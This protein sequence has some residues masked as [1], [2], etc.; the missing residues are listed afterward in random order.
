MAKVL[1][2]QAPASGDAKPTVL[3]PFTKASREHSEGAFLDTTVLE[4]TFDAGPTQLAP[5]D[6]PAFGYMRDILLLVEASGGDDGLT[7]AVAQ[8]DAPWSVIRSL[9]LKDVN[10]Q[11]IVGPISGYDLMLL[12]KW[13]GYSFDGDPRR[14]PAFVDVDTNGDFSF[15]LRIPVE[16]VSRNA[17]GALANMNASSTYKLE[18]TVADDADVYSTPPGTTTPDVRIRAWLE[19]WAPPGAQDGRGNAQE[20]EPRGLG[21]TQYSSKATYNTAVGSNTIRLAR[22]GNLI[23]TLIFVVRDDGNDR[24][25]ANAPDPLQIHLD[26]RIILNEGSLIR[27]SLMAERYGYE[28]APITTADDDEGVFVF[29]FSHDFDGK[30]GGE[31]GDLWLPTV[32]ST[33]LEVVG[34]FLNDAG[35][36][37]VLTNDIAPVGALM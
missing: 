16:I 13:G 23:R 35:T 36:L 26:G 7:P 10:G 18:I 24:E 4:A 19:A 30:P 31:L 3:V 37:D 21:T 27:R 14:S 33:R 5:R 9:T 12:N 8:A 34:S 1:T 28:L 20:T 2:A 6:V 15:I 29:D 22:V 25:G 32:Q 11:P 17:L